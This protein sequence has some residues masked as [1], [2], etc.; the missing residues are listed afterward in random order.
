MGVQLFNGNFTS[1]LTQED[2]SRPDSESS[3]KVE[4]LA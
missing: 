3:N 4:C 2:G 1:A